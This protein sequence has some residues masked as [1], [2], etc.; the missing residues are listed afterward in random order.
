VALS[1]KELEFR[2][3][4]AVNDYVVKL[5]E[6]LDERLIDIYRPDILSHVLGGRNIPEYHTIPR[7]LRERV[8]EEIIRRYKDSG[9]IVSF[10]DLGTIRFDRI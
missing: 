8:I 6:A 10:S 9:W 5:E 4:F 2:Q 3:D 1:P 7:D